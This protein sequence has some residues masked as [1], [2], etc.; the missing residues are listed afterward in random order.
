[1]GDARREAW[2]ELAL[3]ALGAPLCAL[4]GYAPPLLLD[5]AGTVDLMRAALREIVAV[6][7]AEG[8]S[9]DADECWSALTDALV[10]K[11]G[12]GG[13]RFWAVRRD[14][15]RLSRSDIDRLN[16]AIVAAGRRH[17]IATPYNET[18]LWLIRAQERRD[19]GIQ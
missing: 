6:A 3:A 2:H 5:H 9:L 10:D 19:D 1:V 7:A 11:A 18:I 16:G 12:P 4:L 14:L 17:G 13:A 8:T 15:E